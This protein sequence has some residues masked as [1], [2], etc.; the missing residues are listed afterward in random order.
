MVIKFTRMLDFGGEKGFLDAVDV[1]HLDLGSGCAG[2]FT[3]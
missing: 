1:L 2:V 3:M